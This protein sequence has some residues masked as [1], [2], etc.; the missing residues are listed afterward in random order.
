MRKEV[1]FLDNTLPNYGNLS[2]ALVAD[3]WKAVRSTSGNRLQIQVKYAYYLA[4]TLAAKH[5]ISTSALSPADLAAIWQR[6]GSETSRFEM[7]T[8]DVANNNTAMQMNNIEAGE[9][10]A[11]EENVERMQP[12]YQNIEDILADLGALSFGGK[13]NRS[14]MTRKTHR[15]AHRKTLNKNKN[16]KG[17]YKKT[18]RNKKNRRN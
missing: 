6:A 13:K 11:S 8:K 17:G 18:H 5:G 9:E 15:K 14:H 10:F 12:H 16:K 1:T 4:E 3:G 7:Y 2:R